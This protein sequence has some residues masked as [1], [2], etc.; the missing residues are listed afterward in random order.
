MKGKYF[1]DIS[2]VRAGGEN[3]VPLH[4]ADEMVVFK[5]FKKAGFHFPLHKMLHG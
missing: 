3:I 4:E 1:Y 5:S 2:K